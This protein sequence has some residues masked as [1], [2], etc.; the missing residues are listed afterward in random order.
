[1]PKF[2]A[3]LDEMK[4]RG[5]CALPALVGGL[6]VIPLLAP[7]LGGTECPV[8]SASELGPDPASSRQFLKPT[9][10]TLKQLQVKVECRLLPCPET[11]VGQSIPLGLSG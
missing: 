6:A 5:R 4:R 10:L 3:L 2:V 1:M 7:R 9:A 8:C 11:F